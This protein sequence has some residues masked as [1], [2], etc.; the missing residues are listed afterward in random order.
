MVNWRPA[1]LVL[2]AGAGIFAGWPAQTSPPAGFTTADSESA[3]AKPAAAPLKPVTGAAAATPS[4]EPAPATPL[5]PAPVMLALLRGTLVAVNQANITGNYS[6]LRDLSAPSFRESHN[7]A[8]LTDLFRPWR[9]NALDF[10]AVLL[11]DAKLT[12][13]PKI[14]PDGRLRL[15]GFFPTTPL[16]IGF[17]LGFEA[18]DGNWRL[19]TIAVDARA[20]ETPV[21]EVPRQG[22]PV[23]T[24]AG[25]AKTAPAPAAAGAV[26]MASSAAAPS[27]RQPEPPRPKNPGAAAPFDMSV[28]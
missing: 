8:Q 4:A 27:Q 10:A 1:L 7:A 12:A 18:V 17:D 15:T 28:R 22:A 19:A 26:K 16:R 25:A 2:A 5:P 13:M 14:G 9:E 6:V 20:A 24:S 3:P 11:L 23:A 21:A